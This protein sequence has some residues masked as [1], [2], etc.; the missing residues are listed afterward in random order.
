MSDFTDHLLGHVRALLRQEPRFASMS[1]VELDAYLGDLERDIRHDLER[2]AGSMERMAYED[3]RADL[4]H[5]A[6]MRATAKKAK[7]IK[8]QVAQ[9]QGEA[10]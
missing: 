3:A 8:P 6:E 5:E 2:W 1:R 10:A 9:K 7:R 4:E